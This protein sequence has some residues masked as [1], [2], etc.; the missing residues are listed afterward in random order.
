MLLVAASD[1]AES[2]FL[3]RGPRALPKVRFCVHSIARCA[4][5]SQ[6]ASKDELEDQYW[7]RSCADLQH[8]IGVPWND[9]RLAGF[10]G[11]NW[12]TLQVPL[13]PAEVG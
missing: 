4:G 12:G 6:A 8:G 5:S 10:V 9:C 2:G 3:R 1:P 11:R 13:S 7:P